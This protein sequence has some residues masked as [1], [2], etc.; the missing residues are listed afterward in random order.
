MQVKSKEDKKLPTENKAESR[1]PRALAESLSE[2]PCQ[3][4]KPTFFKAYKIPK[5]P[6]EKL[7]IQE[8]LD[9]NFNFKKNSAASKEDST[10]SEVSNDA[11]DFECESPLAVPNQQKSALSPSDIEG[12]KKTAAEYKKLRETPKPSLKLSV[13]N[14]FK[15]ISSRR[16]VN[17]TRKPVRV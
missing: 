8:A 2:E 16:R 12:L 3:Q 13:F 5:K 9:E 7:N 15:G 14:P 4:E 10:I 6:Q 1:D 11:I 17:R